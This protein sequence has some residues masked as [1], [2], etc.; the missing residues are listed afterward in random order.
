MRTRLLLLPAL[1]GAP[2]PLSSQGA[3]MVDEGSFLVSINGQRAGREDFTIRATP[4]G[5]STEYAARATIVYGDRRLSPVLMTDSTGKPVTYEVN[6]QVTGS[7]SE[8]WKG[9][10][11]RGRVSATMETPRGPAAREYIVAEDAIIIDDDVFHQ[12]YFLAR[13]RPT[14]TVAVIVPRRNAQIRLTVTNAGA[15]RVTI[16]TQEL[17]ATRLVLREPSGEQRDVWVDSQSRVLR[18][19]I[20]GRG[21]LAVRGDPP[22]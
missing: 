22:R 13:H 7:A 2:A 12:Y 15:E 4:R 10:I 1:I 16:G 17:D 19:A 14:G 11:V 9:S 21:I 3:R 5:A 8:H 20:P 6:V 18:V